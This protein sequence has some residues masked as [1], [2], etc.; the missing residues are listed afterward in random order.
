MHTAWLLIGPIGHIR[1]SINQQ[2]GRAGRGGVV[3]GRDINKLPTEGT[4]HLCSV[5]AAVTRTWTALYVFNVLSGIRGHGCKPEWVSR[6]TGE[7]DR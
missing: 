7:N 6:E 2:A 3:L 1:G 5:W 4:D